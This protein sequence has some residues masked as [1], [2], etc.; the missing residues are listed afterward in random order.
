MH[1]GRSLRSNNPWPPCR[2][3]TWIMIHFLSAPSKL[4]FLSWSNL[5]K[6]VFLMC[7]LCLEDVFVLV[8]AKRKRRRKGMLFV[9]L[10]RFF[11]FFFFFNNSK[12]SSCSFCFLANVSIFVRLVIAKE[13]VVMLGESLCVLLVG[14]DEIF[15]QHLNLVCFKT[16]FQRVFV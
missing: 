13:I 8:K 14:K 9:E 10:S 3:F 4:I 5:S 12:S 15:G 11:S 1:L 6:D 7:D 2:L 16:T